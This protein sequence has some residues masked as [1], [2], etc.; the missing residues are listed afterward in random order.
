M[1]PTALAE[2]LNASGISKNGIPRLTVSTDRSD[3]AENM[4][5]T[6]RRLGIKTFDRDNS[7]VNTMYPG[8][9]PKNSAAMFAY[10]SAMHA[11]SFLTHPTY[12]A[13]GFTPLSIHQLSA[14]SEIFRDLF[15]NKTKGLDSIK[16]KDQ[17]QQYNDGFANGGLIGYHKGGPVGHKHGPAEAARLKAIGW[18]LESARNSPKKWYSGFKALT[19]KEN[20][21]FGKTHGAVDLPYDAYKNLIFPTAT[22]ADRMVGDTIGGAL[23]IKSPLI[24]STNRNN[25]AQMSSTDIGIEKA[26][27]LLGILPYGRI[28]GKAATAGMSKATIA[29]IAEEKLASKAATAAYRASVKPVPLPYQALNT[30]NQYANYFKAKKLVKDGQ[31]HGSS[32]RGN[33]YDPPFSGKSELDGNYS[34]DPY[35]GMGFFSTSSRAEAD[36]YAGGYNVPGQWGESFGSINRVTKIPRGK[37]IDYRKKNLK[38]QNYLL[39]KLL[40]AKDNHWSRDVSLGMPDYRYAGE[41]LGSLMNQAGTTGSIMPRISAGR[42]PGDI[43]D[44]IWIALNKPKGTTLQETGLGFSSSNLGYQSSGFTYNNRSSKAIQEFLR[45]NL[46]KT[47]LTQDRSVINEVLS[48][49]PI[50][51]VPKT[52]LEDL[53]ALGATTYTSTGNYISLPSKTTFGTTIHEGAHA[54][55]AI[56]GTSVRRF[57]GEVSRTKSKVDADRLSRLWISSQKTT[58]PLYDFINKVRDLKLHPNLLTGIQEATATDAHS[59]AYKNAGFNLIKKLRIGNPYTAGQGYIESFEQLLQYSHGVQSMQGKIDLANGLL[60]SE[61]MSSSLRRQTQQWVRRLENEKASGMSYPGF[62]EF[63]KPGSIG[64][65][66]SLRPNT[67]SSPNANSMFSPPELRTVEDYIGRPRTYADSMAHVLDRFNFGDQAGTFF[68]GLSMHDMAA[69]AGY[70][71]VPNPNLIYGRDYM[72]KW[73]PTS[74]GGF[75]DDTREAPWAHLARSW[76]PEAASVF[77]RGTRSPLPSSE[78]AMPYLNMLPGLKIGEYWRPDTLK[79]ITAELEFAKHIAVSGGTGGGEQK[80]IAKIIVDPKVKGIG[81]FAKF[82]PP[83]AKPNWKGTE[84]TEGAI[85]PFTKYILE[86]INKNAHSVTD[87]AKGV[88]HLIDEYVLRAVETSPYLEFLKRGMPIKD[89]IFGKLLPIVKKATGGY[90]NP[91]YSANM[92]VPQFKDGINM[93]PADMLAMIHKNEAI[94]PANMN[95]FNPNANNATM[96]PAVYNISMTNHAAEGMDVNVFADVTTRKVLA[97]IKR[98]DVQRAS[99]NGMGRR[100]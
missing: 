12:P 72:E 24:T 49:T 53:Q 84:F 83:K 66:E 67:S 71:R 39:W 48:K 76:K 54:L 31:Y 25:R 93:V 77:P 57:I 65:I 91:S 26:V 3:Y 11:N 75:A 9:D 44:A 59:F 80:A 78:E 55:D 17:L 89:D 30:F 4:I 23:N 96:A 32:D 16:L 69:I 41:E 50:R 60:T 7:S 81:D 87:E 20:W 79:S 85:A 14:A 43:N 95:P 21:G 61:R 88:S 15:K 29:K 64:R 99:M 33:S 19:K 68:R 62:D 6:L 63:G 74:W 92:S 5:D 8:I 1:L 56:T 47:G 13:Q 82:S 58:N 2:S 90:I 52:T 35:Y 22:W 40:Q 46:G 97:E 10:E 73:G 18:P 70:T 86:A 37:Y 34:R 38:Y 36:L 45:K 42:A 100:V 94:V 28:V 27:D 51:K 98:L